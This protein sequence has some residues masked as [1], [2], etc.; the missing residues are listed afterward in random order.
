MRRGIVHESPEAYSSV[1][2]SQHWDD[3]YTRKTAKGVSWHRPH[4]ETSLEWIRFSAPSLESRIIDIGGG[5]STLID[6][7][8]ALGYSNLSV[9]DVSKVALD[10]ARARITAHPDGIAWIQGDVTSVTLPPDRYDIWHDRAVFH[11]LTDAND[12][13]RYV[14]AAT[15]AV[16][17]GGFLIVATFAL[18]GPITCSGLPVVRYSS[19]TLVSQFPAFEGIDT[20][21]EAHRTPTGV[22]QS[23]VYCLLKKV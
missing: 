12:R 20:R 6:D 21:H 19:E 4:L 17:V 5:A 7:L 2:N 16:K 18:D 13:N 14:Q 23:F 8:L 3:I 15:N 22:I 9:L 1:M 11:F 10:E